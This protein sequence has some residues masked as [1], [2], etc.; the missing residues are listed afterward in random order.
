M[1]IWCYFILT[2]TGNF[3]AK[4]FLLLNRVLQWAFEGLE[5]LMVK[6]I[7]AVLR[8]ERPRKGPDLPDEDVPAGP[9]GDSLGI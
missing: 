2:V 4:D 8:G 3:I 1:K 7:W 5:P 9:L 6:I